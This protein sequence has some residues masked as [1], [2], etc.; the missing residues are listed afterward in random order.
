MWENVREVFGELI[1][2]GIN[3]FKTPAFSDIALIVSSAKSYKKF[4]K[5]IKDIPYKLERLFKD[6]YFAHDEIENKMILLAKVLQL[7]K[8]IESAK[9]FSLSDEKSDV[10]TGNNAVL[11]TLDNAI[12]TYAKRDYMNNS[13]YTIQKLMETNAIVVIDTQS[14]GED[15]M[16]VFFESILKKA[17]MRL[18][19]SSNTALSVFIDESNRV[20][21][22]SI[23]LHNDVLREASVELVLAIQNNEQMIIKFGKIEWKAIKKNI[24][25]NYSI[26]KDHQITYNEENT[27]SSDPVLIQ[28]KL[29]DDIDYD[30]FMIDKNRQRIKKAFIGTCDNLPT[31]FSVIYDLDLFDRTSEVILEDEQGNKNTYSYFGESILLKVKNSFPDIKTLITYPKKEDDDIEDFLDEDDYEIMDLEGIEEELDIGYLP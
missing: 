20:I 8:N 3:I 23:D 15:V 14:F 5:I 7:N 16:K 29:L 10:N 18:R 6:D 9:R 22:S 28:N 31:R 13:E 2:Y 26:S 11:Q 27:I 30:Y 12:A 4:F 25:H 24:K 17:V 21:S 1:L 19:N